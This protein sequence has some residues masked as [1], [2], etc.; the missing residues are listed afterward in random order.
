MNQPVITTS[1]KKVSF[2]TTKVNDRYVETKIDKMEENVNIKLN[3]ASKCIQ[4]DKFLTAN[5]KNQQNIKDNE[6]NMVRSSFMVQIEDTQI[7][8]KLPIAPEINNKRLYNQM[9]KKL[10]KAEKKYKIPLK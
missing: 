10:L 2:A 7:D 9:N 4:D 6:I 8:N 5:N 1:F 3:K